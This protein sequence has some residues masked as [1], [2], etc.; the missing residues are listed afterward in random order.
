MAIV[1]YTDR[2]GKTRRVSITGTLA[3][4]RSSSEDLPLSDPAVSKHHAL[5]SCDDG[6]CYLKDRGSSNGTY[7]NGRKVVDRKKLR[8]GDRIVIGET[9]LQFFEQRDLSQSQ[10]EVGDD[11]THSAIKR[12]LEADT[13]AQFLPAEKIEDIESLRRDY[14]KLRIAH[15]L[16]LSIQPEMEIEDLLGQI[17]EQAVEMFDAD[18]GV[19]LLDEASN[20]QL[21]PAA[22]RTHD[23]R[24]ST[25]I[26]ISHSIVDEVVR[27][28]CAVLSQDAMRDER[29]EESESVFMEQIRSAL[30]V[31]M[32][33]DQKLLGAIYLDSKV[34]SHRFHEKD[35]DLLTGFAQQASAMV[36][37][38]QL[39]KRMEREMV[40][41]EKLSRLLSP[42]L[43]E[44]VVEGRLDIEKGGQIREVTVLFADVRNFTTW[45]EKLSPDEILEHLN[46]YFE[47]MVDAVFAHEGT[48][49]KFIGDEMMCVWGAP[50][51]QDDHPERA[52]RCALEIQEIVD[53]FNEKRAAEG[54]VVFDIGI[55]VNTGETIAGYT[56]SSRSMNYTV[57]GDAVNTAS[58][59]CSKADGGEILIGEQT[60]TGA[61]DLVT[62]ERIADAKLRNKIEQLDIYRVTG[63]T[64]QFLDEDVESS[65]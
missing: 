7:L 20:G 36:A 40:A 25:D 22:I 11:D 12:R 44:E 48:L 3:I 64:S 38:H 63:R 45:S 54:D 56:G 50:I 46:K 41:R 15:R 33:R 18:R 62:V 42:Q 26:R 31:P 5:I 9:E 27:N 35:L 59:I 16:S 19:A 2:T 53:T 55:G 17:L 13:G 39:R 61:R 28:Q 1:S 58:R 14:E 52:V 37:H 29:F 57:M 8:D 23:G 10:V 24:D 32:L 30:C 60:H 47:L 21:E 43:V 65:S 34:A 49:D 51:A 6:A 4:G